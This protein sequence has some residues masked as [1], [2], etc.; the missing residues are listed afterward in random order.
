[1]M[2][3]FFI[4]AHRLGFSTW[5]EED[6]ND[7][8]ELW[9]NPEVT[10][11]IL[12]NGKMSDIQVQERLKS[13]I[14]NYSCKGIQYWPIFL[15]ETNENIGCCGLRSYNEDKKILEMGIHLKEKY[16]GKGYAQEACSAVMKY[17]FNKLGANALFAGH[18]PKNSA[19]AVLLR[20]LGF[21]YTHDEYYAPTGLYHPSYILKRDDYFERNKK[22]NLSFEINS[23]YVCVKDMD[24]AIEFY[25]KL[26]DQRVTVRNEIY[27]VFDINGFRYGLFANYKVNEAK[28]WGNNCLPSLAVNDMDLIMQKLR[29]LK[30]SIV[31]PLT[32]IGKNKVI[33]FTDSEGNNVEVTCLI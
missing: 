2:R 33:E 13:E 19:S 5:N 30:C 1:M 21:I 32:I 11:Y 4:K 22:V 20:K 31:F 18:N 12:A 27:S 10:K 17:A 16:W 8:R 28:V 6:I 25:E 7:A 24:R 14:E 26:L 9:R 23:L 29:D 3:N 15:I